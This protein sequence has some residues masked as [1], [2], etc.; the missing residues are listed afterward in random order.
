MGSDWLHMQ[1]AFAQAELALEMGEVP[2]GCVFVDQA[3]N[4]VIAVGHNK[5]NKACNATQH[6][7]I[8]ALQSCGD[9]P[10]PNNVSVYVTLEPCIMCAAA[11]S[12]AGVHT[13]VFGAGND[14]FGGCGSVLDVCQSFPGEA[15]LREFP[16]MRTG[17]GS[18]QAIELLQR[19]YL[20]TN[21]KAPVP[22]LDGMKERVAKRHQNV[23]NNNS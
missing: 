13:V 4:S 6:A 15:G 11:L 9:L 8:I 20:R 5:T 1:G 12:I 19:F 2:V 16:V 3:S 17:L 21:D 7:E 22:R 23:H 18:V 14:K 10:F